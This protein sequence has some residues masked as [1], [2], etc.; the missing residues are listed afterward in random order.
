LSETRRQPSLARLQDAHPKIRR[1][2]HRAVDPRRAVDADKDERR[3]ER[4]GER[5]IGQVASAR[6]FRAPW[7]LA[8]RLE[9]SR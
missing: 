7:S 5:R 2:H 1:R 3:D 9:A 8:L 6:T 4:V